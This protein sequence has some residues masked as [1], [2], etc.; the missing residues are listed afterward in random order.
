MLTI[1]IHP[2]AWKVDS[3]KFGSITWAASL[4]H[5]LDVVW[6]PRSPD[7]RLSTQA[8]SGSS[9]VLN[10]LICALRHEPQLRNYSMSRME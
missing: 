5:G 3:Q 6:N 4:E 10:V 2:S 8:V 7:M 9:L 1:F